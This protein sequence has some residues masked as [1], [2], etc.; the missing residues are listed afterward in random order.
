[1]TVQTELRNF[2][3]ELRCTKMALSDLIPLLQKAADRID[4]LEKDAQY[5]QA[6]QFCA[7]IFK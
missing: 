2:A 7:G 1:M 4:Q 5:T 6:Q 3:L